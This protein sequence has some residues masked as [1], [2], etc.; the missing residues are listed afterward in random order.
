M[1]DDIRMLGGRSVLLCPADGPLLASEADALDLI[2]RLWG[3]EVDWLA[4]PKLRLGDGFLTLRTGLAGAVIQKFVTYSVRLAIVG[5][6]SAEVAASDALKDFV[7]ESN[8]GSRVW[9]VTDM[10][11]LEARL[12]GLG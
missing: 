8:A 12:A 5:D 11:T 10:A 9:F 1:G 7:R 4:V 3:R 2:G 6:V